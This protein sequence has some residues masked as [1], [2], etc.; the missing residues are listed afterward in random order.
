MH[1]S[2]RSRGCS[3]DVSYDEYPAHEA[4]EWTKVFIVT[5]H[6]IN[7]LVRPDV[8]HAVVTGPLPALVP[9]LQAPSAAPRAASDRFESKKE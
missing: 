2:S 3:P 1:D 7:E 5:D 8:V 6:I 4:A 9:C